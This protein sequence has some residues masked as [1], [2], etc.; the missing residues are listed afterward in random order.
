MM[1]AQGG[2]SGG[3]TPKADAVK[4]LSKGGCVKMLTGGGGVK[5]SENFA[6]PCIKLKT[7]D[8]EFAC[9]GFEP[10]PRCMW[11]GMSDAKSPKK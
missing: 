10:R 2:G 7:S 9:P 1:S 6:D 11:K 8:Y 3:G 4:K 5:K